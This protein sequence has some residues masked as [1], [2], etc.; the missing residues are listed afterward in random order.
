MSKVDEIRDIVYINGYV[1][2][3]CFIIYGIEFKEF[4]YFFFM[5]FVNILLL[6]YGFEDSD[7]Y[8]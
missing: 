3:K 7:Y 5:L 8:Y 1:N 6:K 4:Y 2:K